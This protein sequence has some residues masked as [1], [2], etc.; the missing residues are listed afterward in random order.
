[1]QLRAEGQ[2]IFV[3]VE[4]RVMM[5]K[6]FSLSRIGTA[7][8][9]KRTRRMGQVVG[10]VLPGHSTDPGRDLIGA[11]NLGG[12][13]PGPGGGSGIVAQ[14]RIPLLEAELILGPV[15]GT[16]MLDDIFK[17]GEQGFTLGVEKAD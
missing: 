10:E 15:G 1:M 8:K 6:S 11:N 16:D 17:T 9:G 3:D 4:T 13:L 12:R 14:Q 7:D 2:G 5:G